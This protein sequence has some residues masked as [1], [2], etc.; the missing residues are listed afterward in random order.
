MGLTTVIVGLAKP[1][2][3]IIAI[4]A[5][6]TMGLLLPI[7][8]G[9]YGATLQAVIKPEMQGRVF[10]FI[11][12]AAMLVSPIALIIAGPFA[13]N[14]GI[15]PWFIIAGISCIVMGLAGF[16]IPDVMSIENKSKEEEAVNVATQ[17]S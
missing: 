5:N 8:N 17:P 7:I 10:A 3:F 2:M 16:F 1:D 11:M 14:F 13:D 12:S 4:I 9:S 15:Q 6:T